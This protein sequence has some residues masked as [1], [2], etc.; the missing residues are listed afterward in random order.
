MD[1]PRITPDQVA[2]R[3]H[4]GEHITF[5]DARSAKA[6]ERATEQLPKSVRVPPDDIDRH[7]SGLPRSA[8]FVAYCT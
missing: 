4:R 5:L 1:I 6:M 7:V 8:T 3:L 2:E